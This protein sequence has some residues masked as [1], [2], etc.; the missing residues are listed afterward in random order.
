MLKYNFSLNLLLILNIYLTIRV[1]SL[2]QNGWINGNSFSF[3][4]KVELSIEKE[5][6]E[7]VPID[8]VPLF[9]DFKS[10]QGLYS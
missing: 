7:I 8:A 1:L 4:L 10:S 9:L 5:Y 3:K 2:E 6:K